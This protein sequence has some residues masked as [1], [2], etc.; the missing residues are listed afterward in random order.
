MLEQDAKIKVVFRGVRG[1]Y[2]V[3]GPT[4]LL[5]GGNTSCHEVHAG[6]RT[7]IFDAGTGIISLGRDLMKQGLKHDIALFISHDHHDHTA[8]LM[9]FG[10]CFSK[11]TNLY[12]YGP[13]KEHGGILESLDTLTAPTA[14]PIHFSQ[15]G[16]HYECTEAVAGMMVRWAPDAPAPAVVPADTPIAPSDIV[17]RVFKNPKH[18]LGGVYNFRLEYAGKSYVYASDVEGTPGQGDAALAEFAR[19]ADLLCHDGQYR[20]EDYPTRVGWGHSTAQ[21]AIQTAV[22]AG[23]KR[24]AIIHH[25]PTYDDARLAAMEEEAKG[26]FPG[27]FYAKE[28]MEIEF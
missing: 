27:I 19:G 11:Q 24:L 20:E 10:P 4:T 14:H 28:N 12:V 26:A 3:P 7:L 15:M 5:Y 2:P 22:L 6:G 8:G 1:S 21:M 18:P 25:E 9:Y 13:G 23:A 17:V 16:M